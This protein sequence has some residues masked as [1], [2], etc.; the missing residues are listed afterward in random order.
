MG[1]RRGSEARET[2]RI[3][4]LERPVSFFKDFRFYPKSYVRKDTKGLLFCFEQENDLNRIVFV[5]RISFLCGKSV[6]CSDYPCGWG[7]G[8]G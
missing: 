7:G 2:L 6:T 8:K 3:W 4:I 1:E 5:K